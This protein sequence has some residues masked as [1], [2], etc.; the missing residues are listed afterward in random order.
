MQFMEDII[1]W[2]MPRGLYS[3]CM[4]LLDTRSQLKKGMSKLGKR[5]GS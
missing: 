5:G 2:R 1:N 4:S 3:C